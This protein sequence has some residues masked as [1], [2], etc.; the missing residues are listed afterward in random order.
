MYKFAAGIVCVATLGLAG[1]CSSGPRTPDEFRVVRKAP[2]TVPPEYSLRPPAPGEARPQ[3][4]APDAEARVA[5]FGRDFGA[6]ASAGEQAL[7]AKA[8]GDAVDRSIRAS[9]DYDSSQ[10]LKKS[11]SF[12]DSV[13]SFGGN[14]SDTVV[15]AAAEAERLRSEQDA[16]QEVTGGG[17]VM[18]RRKSSSKLPGL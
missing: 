14:R 1:A 17:D 3:E 12:A 4:L 10:S 2:L 6:E 7:V 8:G 11:Q 9:V 13:L 5:V 15:D 18:I 16:A